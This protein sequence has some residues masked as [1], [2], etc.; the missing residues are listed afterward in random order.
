MKVLKLLHLEWSLLNG[1]ATARFMNIRYD[2][3]HGEGNIILF[4][5]IVS[6]L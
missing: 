2:V 6:I 5:S 4:E 3:S 1:L